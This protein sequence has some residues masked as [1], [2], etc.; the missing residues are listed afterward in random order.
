MPISINLA[1]FG[2][3]ADG[4]HQTYDVT[5][6]AQRMYDQGTRV[7]TADRTVWG[8]PD[9]N[10]TKGLAMV[11]TDGSDNYGAVTFEH[12]GSGITLPS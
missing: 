11:W 2:L 12:G 1:V 6:L 7:F 10:H 8:D 3:D 5:G 9:Q 4:D